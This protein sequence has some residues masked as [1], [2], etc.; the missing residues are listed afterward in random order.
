[1]TFRLFTN[2]ATM[3]SQKHIYE[4]VPSSGE[5]SSP[6]LHHPALVGHTSSSSHRV[7]RSRVLHIR[8]R[9][10]PS[11]L[12]STV[13][14]VGI[15]VPPDGMSGDESRQ[16]RLRLRSRM[17]KTPATVPDDEDPGYGAG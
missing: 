17:M 1:M 13:L 2:I 6:G 3:D 7:F 16:A 4:Y 12:I 10:R 14:L 9:P 8:F 15:S 11:L 5:H